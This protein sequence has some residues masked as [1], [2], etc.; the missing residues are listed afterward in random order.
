MRQ[1]RD[2]SRNESMIRSLCFIVTRNVA[3]ILYFGKLMDSI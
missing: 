2:D 1:T 3:P